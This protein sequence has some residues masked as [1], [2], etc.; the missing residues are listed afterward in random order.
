MVFRTDRTNKLIVNKQIRIAYSSFHCS[1]SGH[2]CRKKLWNFL[3]SPTHCM[4]PSLQLNAAHMPSVWLTLCRIVT[5]WDWNPGHMT[6]RILVECDWRIHRSTPAV[7]ALSRT[8][9]DACTHHTR[10]APVDN[11]SVVGR[12]DMRLAEIFAAASDWHYGCRD[13]RRCMSVCVR[14]VCVRVTFAHLS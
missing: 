7:R 2:V 4:H 10:Q 13:G 8:T 1:S 14:P 9:H 3:L 12:Y 5:C 6:C 11:L